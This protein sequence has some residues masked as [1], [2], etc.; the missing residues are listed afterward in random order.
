MLY[1]DKANFELVGL[2]SMSLHPDNTAFFE[3]NVAV[4]ASCWQ[5]VQFDQSGM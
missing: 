3:E 5:H 4:V 2:I 1:Y